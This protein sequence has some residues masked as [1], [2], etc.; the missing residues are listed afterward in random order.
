[1]DWMIRY[2]DQAK[3]GRASITKVGEGDFVISEKAY[4]PTTGA[5]VS[6]QEWHFTK[7]EIDQKILA[8]EEREQKLQ[9]ELTAVGD[10]IASVKALR[11]E[12]AKESYK[13]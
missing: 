5:R 13:D 8:L 11:D 2:S 9:N 3:E 1:M 10:K 6:D 7:S 12:M 4:D